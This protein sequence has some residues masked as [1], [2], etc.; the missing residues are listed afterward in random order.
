MRCTDIGTSHFLL[1]NYISVGTKNGLFR[2]YHL[3]ALP[4]LIVP[5]FFAE[6]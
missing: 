3:P 4:Y 6:K 1:G 2:F 5:L